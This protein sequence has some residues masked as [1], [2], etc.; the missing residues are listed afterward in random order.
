MK[1]IRI[2]EFETNS[3]STHSLNICT[4]DEWNDWI[5]GKLL[6]NPYKKKFIDSGSNNPGK[7][8]YYTYDEYW[9]DLNEYLEGYDEHYTSKSGDEIVIFGAY[10]YNG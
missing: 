3:S 10:G 5:S 6:F 4:I 7:G 9:D 2:G 8:D 1:Q